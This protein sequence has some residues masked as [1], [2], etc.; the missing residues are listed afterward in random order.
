MDRAKIASLCSLASFLCVLLPP[1]S[2]DANI[3][4]S[5]TAIRLGIHVVHRGDT[6]WDLAREYHTHI[7]T[8]QSLNR[9]SGDLIIV[10]QRLL[11]PGAAG[12]VAAKSSR[13]A[14][15]ASAPPRR[16]WAYRL[17][18]A[19]CIKRT[20]S[21]VS[22][23]TLSELA[24]SYGTTVE[25]IAGANGVR[26]HIIRIGQVLVIPTPPDARTGSRSWPGAYD[27]NVRTL[28]R[29]INAEARG[30]SYEGQVAVGAVVLNRLIHPSFP[31]SIEKVIRE[32]DAFTSV[33][34]GQFR[35]PP[36]NGALRA[37]RE[38]LEGWDPTHGA[39]YFYNP[40]QATAK[41][42]FS[43]PR[44]RTIGHHVFTV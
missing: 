38:A 7:A 27:R 43:R 29:I 23:D 30:E 28:A 24:E 31:K 16:L 25:L 6:L 36:G 35:L 3:P 34:D 5:S 9:L 21:V 42:S 14:P 8:I 2:S 44:V 10:G 22:G 4:G 12:Q 18:L 39:L 20:H 15:V 11:L 33:T 32:P 26:S 1:G 41:W 19:A 13:P 40:V 37:A 17:P